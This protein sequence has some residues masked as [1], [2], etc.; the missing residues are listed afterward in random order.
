M[1]T[2]QPFLLKCLAITGVFCVVAALACRHAFP[3]TVQ[4]MPNPFEQLASQEADTDFNVVVFSDIA[5]N[6]Q[7]IDQELEAVNATGAD[8]AI[9]NGDLVNYGSS[10][11]EFNYVQRKLIQKIKMPLFILPGNHDNHPEV[12]FERYRAFFGLEHY[13]WS[14][15]DTL[16]VAI[17]T[18]NR[19]FTDS[20]CLFLKQ[21][22]EQERSKFRRCV[23]VMHCPPVDLRPH[24]KTHAM[25][26]QQEIDALA[27]LVAAHHV[28][29]IVTSHLHWFLEGRFGG[30]PIFHTP[31]GGQRV[32]DTGNPNIGYVLMSFKKDGDIQ[33]ER[34]NVTAER[35]RNL[36]FVCLMVARY[37]PWIVGSGLMLLS[38]SACVAL[39][40]LWEMVKRRTD[41]YEN[42]SYAA[43][44]LEIVE[45]RRQAGQ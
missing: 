2:R 34:V 22:L 38:V 30:A 36:E 16:F 27:D 5:H 33:L 15:A 3:P 42:E 21:T 37:F 35:G 45:C 6:Y 40:S 8:F 9:C 29:M 44:A 23:L 12:G 14:Y 10:E 4:K 13:F 41:V 18:A 25:K 17:N 43:N 28:D 26:I 32:R 7:T 1:K 20:E 24:K 19:H 31:S 39:L 11:N